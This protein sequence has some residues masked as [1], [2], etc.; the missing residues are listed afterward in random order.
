METAYEHTG[1]GT[2]E[3]LHMDA[4]SYEV[5]SLTASTDRRRRTISA[6]L[7][8]ALFLG[9]TV[10]AVASPNGGVTQVVERA[11][12]PKSRPVRG[13]SLVS[14][15]EID[16]GFYELSTCTQ[17]ID[18]WEFLRD[19]PLSTLTVIDA[20]TL[21]NFND[22]T[23]RWI[24]D[25]ILPELGSVAND[26]NE[27]LKYLTALLPGADVA[28]LKDAAVFYEHVRTLEWSPDIWSDEGEITFEWIAGLKHAIVTF[29]GDGRYGYALRHGDAFRAGE[30]GDPLPDVFPADLRKYLGRA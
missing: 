3:Y 20:T 30:E 26:N 11:A 14:V 9:S 1:A 24:D 29:D 22:L 8:N 6:V 17:S 4:N 28:L 15:G 27:S 7:A 13:D 18:S 25:R 23:K 10:A 2:S 16:L 21:A 12:S 19:R 5:S